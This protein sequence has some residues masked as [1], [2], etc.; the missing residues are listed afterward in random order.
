MSGLRIEVRV[1]DIDEYYCGVNGV[2]GVQP[3][4]RVM[5]FRAEGAG[6][7]RAKV[8]KEQIEDAEV[9]G[10]SFVRGRSLAVLRSRF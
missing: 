5:R 7:V 3:A 9:Q 1:N 2:L 4:P 10:D 6:G 8:A